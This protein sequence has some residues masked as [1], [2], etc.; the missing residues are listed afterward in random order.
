MYFHKMKIKDIFLGTGLVLF[1]SFWNVFN[2][3]SFFRHN[4]FFVSLSLADPF[5]SWTTFK[6]FVKCN[7]EKQ[8][9][10]HKI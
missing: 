1:I 6:K 9:C 7:Q 8:A 10:C 2:E 4:N 3:L 5:G